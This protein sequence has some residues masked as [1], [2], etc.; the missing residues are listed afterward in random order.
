MLNTRIVA[1]LLAGAL[2]TSGTAAMAEDGFFLKLAGTS[3]HFGDTEG[4]DFNTANLGLGIGYTWSG[5]DLGPVKDVDVSLSGTVY[6]DS[7]YCDA[8][9]VQLRGTK[10]V[11]KRLAVGLALN[12]AHKCQT[13]NSEPYGFI[14]PTL[15]ATYDLSD[16]FSLAFDAAPAI[17]DINE[18]GFV[19][20]SLE[21]KF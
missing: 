3:V 13:P 12:A 9:N 18:I 10:A 1:T 19:G 15:V 16:R 14:A 6:R 7:F 20:V 4:V 8:V 2:L 21:M 5:V 17:K 11:S